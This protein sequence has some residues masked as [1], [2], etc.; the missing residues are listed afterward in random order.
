MQR[1]DPVEAYEDSLAMQQQADPSCW[2]ALCSTCWP[3]CLFFF[4]TSATFALRAPLAQLHSIH[5][6]AVFG[7]GFAHRWIAQNGD[8]PGADFHRSR[9]SRLSSQA[10]L[11]FCLRWWSTRAGTCSFCSVLPVASPLP[12]PFAG[13][14]TSITL[15]A[16][17]VRI[18]G[19]SGDRARA[20]RS[21]EVVPW[22]PQT[23]LCRIQWSSWGICRTGVQKFWRG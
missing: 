22:C 23:S 21:S 17:V 12:P 1:T 8:L 13:V 3:C 18:A 15:A 20:G 5:S 7:C 19:Q 9:D 2:S 10:Q 14:E 4:W 16:P 6:P 11:L